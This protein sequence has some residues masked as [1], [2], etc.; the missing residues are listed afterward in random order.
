MNSKFVYCREF[1]E[2]Q[3][4]KFTL[5]ILNEGFTASLFTNLD[6]SPISTYR[7]TNTNA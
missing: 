3:F 1:P 6:L 2:K 5:F 4:T 7:K